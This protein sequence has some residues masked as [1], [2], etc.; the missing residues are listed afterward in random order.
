MFGDIPKLFANEE[1]LRKLWSLPNTRKKL[2]EALSERGYTL[3]QL[4]DLRNVI[5][6]QDSDLY[7][8]L[9]YVAYHSDLVPRAER[10]E[11]AKI[12]FDSY[13]QEQQE[14]LNFVLDQ[15]VKSG[16]EELDDNKLSELLVLKYHAISDA[17]SK[18]GDI[19][20][21]RNTFIGFQEHLYRGKVG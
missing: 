13:N 8:V 3:V 17:K 2:M 4:E 1:E 16:V 20:T 15:Y 11:K 21:I 6:G 18:L 12:H 19:P 7:D 5:Q 9:S 10:A 14:F